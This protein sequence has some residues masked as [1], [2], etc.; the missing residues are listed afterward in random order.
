MELTKRGVVAGIA[1]LIG[2]FAAAVPAHAGSGGAFATMPAA[3]SEVTCVSGCASID[4]AQPGSVLRVRG[5]NMRDVAKIVFLGGSGHADN[6]TAK[7]LKRR[8]ASVDVA[9]PERA[10]SG[11]LRAVNGD[12]M[13]SAASRAT[14][15]IERGS[16]MKGTLDVKVIGRRVFYDAERAARID[17]LVREPMS[18]TV[19]LVRLSDGAIVAGWPL[20]PLVPGVARTVVWDGTITGLPQPAGRYE[21]QVFSDGGVQA[22]QAVAA[23]PGPLATGIFDL[24]DHKFPVRGKHDFGRGEAAFGAGRDGHAHQ[25]HDVFAACGTPLV[26]ARGGVVKLNQHE[27]RAGNYLVIDGAGTDVDYAYMHL[28]EPS[29]L[30]KGDRVMT[31]QVIGAVGDTGVAHGC[32][33]HFEMWSGPGLVQRRRA[34]GPAAV[35]AGVGRLQLT[36]R[37]RA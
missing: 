20:G 7:V 25:G 12:G 5:R 9:V 21:F 33:L 28:Q 37:A 35:A 17:I 23:A 29:P 4:A 19:A 1:G 13:R 2:T 14:V 22:A 31:G 26:A 6:A 27:G 32:H 15:S 30:Q 34:D 11:R 8:L 10:A 36:A 16:A 3:I 24:V 18:L